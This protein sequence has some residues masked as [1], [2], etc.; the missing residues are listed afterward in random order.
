M[1]EVQDLH[2]SFG[3]VEVLKGVSLIAHKGEVISLIGASGSGKSTF[4]RCINFLELPSRG[5][6][7]IGNEELVMEPR[8]DGNLHAVDARQLMRL[9]TQLGM[10]FQNFNL[11]QHM[12]A[13]QNVMEAPV[14][15]L[16]LSRAEAKDRAMHYMAKVGVSDKKDAYPAT[17]SGGQ[18][19]RVAIARALAM[20]PKALLFDEPTSALDPMLSEEVNRVI[21]DLADEGRTMVIVTHDLAFAK[22][23]STHVMFLNDGLTLEQGTASDMFTKPRSAALKRFIGGGSSVK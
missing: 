13:L 5:R 15:V 18:A 6:I 19:Q 1:I 3:P 10:V 7:V 8:A 11:W 21:T 23:V 4:L 17:L 16:K 20:E 14:H 2:K 12:T 9:R 22:T